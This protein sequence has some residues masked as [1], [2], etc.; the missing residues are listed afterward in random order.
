MH[1]LIHVHV[2]LYHR[3]LLHHHQL[4]MEALPQPK[5]NRIMLEEE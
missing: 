3:K 1:A 5:V 4:T 2:H